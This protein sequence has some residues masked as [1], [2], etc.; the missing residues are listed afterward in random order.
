MITVFWKPGFP[1]IWVL[2]GKNMGFYGKNMGFYGKN[3]GYPKFPPA[4][5][6]K[7]AFNSIRLIFFYLPNRR[8]KLPFD[9]FPI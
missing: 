1:E 7:N 2:Y 8:K 3:M 5:F 9:L 4:S 6:K